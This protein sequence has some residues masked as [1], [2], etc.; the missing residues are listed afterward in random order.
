MILEFLWLEVAALGLDDVLGEFEH[1][2]GDVASRLS[3]K[4][5]D[6]SRTSY[7]YLNRVPIKPLPRGSRAITC[8]LLVSTTRP[9]A[10][11]SIA[12]ITS[13]ITA[14]ASTPTFPS[15]AM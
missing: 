8:S 10:T 6:L 11:R 3:S 9:R 4:Y 14:K 5:S 7:G 1:V 2:L 15:G 13:R 12:S